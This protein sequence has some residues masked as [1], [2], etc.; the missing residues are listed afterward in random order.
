MKRFGRPPIAIKRG[1]GGK[2]EA[3]RGGGGGGGSDGGA[4]STA[5]FEPSAYVIGQDRTVSCKGKSIGRKKAAL[6]RD[7]AAKVVKR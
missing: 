3:G 5:R 6:L 4:S 7:M 2:G 1:A